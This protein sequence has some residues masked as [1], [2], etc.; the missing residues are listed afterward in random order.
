MPAFLVGIPY[1]EP[2][3]HRLW[4]D[5]AIEDYESST[6]LFVEATDAAEAIAWGETVGAELLRYV[7]RDVSLDWKGLG[8]RCWIV[9]DPASSDW[10]HCLDFFQRVAAG[11]MPSLEAMTTASYERWSEASQ[12]RD[13]RGW[14]MNRFRSAAVE[15]RRKLLSEE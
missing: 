8:Y 14:L 15:F 1:H 4:M 2:I 11:E 6:G 13:R 9:P 3:P 5:G 10:S 12:P 7:N